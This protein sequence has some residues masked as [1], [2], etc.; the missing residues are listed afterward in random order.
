LEI[1]CADSLFYRQQLHI[2]NQVREHDGQRLNRSVHSGPAAVFSFSQQALD[3]AKDAARSQI[4]NRQQ[5]NAT[6][7]LHAA[8]ARETPPVETVAAL[9][10]AMQAAQVRATQA[11]PPRAA[12]RNASEVSTSS[13]SQRAPSS[14]DASNLE[15]RPEVSYQ[16]LLDNVPRAFADEI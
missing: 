5:T 13:K 12:F 3:S 7:P 10:P 1:N 8:F 16:S 15:R 11:D 4:G 6:A 2:D 14:S 9:P